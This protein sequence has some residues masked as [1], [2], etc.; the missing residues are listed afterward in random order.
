MMIITIEEIEE[1]EVEA[2]AEVKHL[3]EEEIT[4]PNRTIGINL[5]TIRTIN[6]KKEKITIKK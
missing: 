2:E 4:L 1:V 6:M 3:Q 5:M